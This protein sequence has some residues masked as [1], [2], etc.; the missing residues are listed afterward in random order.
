MKFFVLGAH[1]ELSRTEIETVTGAKLVSLAHPEIMLLDGITTP[2]TELQ[3]RLAGVI[4][5]GTIVGSL[6]GFDKQKTADLI[7][8]Y[9][10][11]YDGK[12][13]FG[14]STYDKRIAK[15][16]QPLGLEVKKRLKA[17]GVSCRLVTSRETALSSVVVQ[18]NHLLEK[19]GEFIVIPNGHE[20]LIGKTET[21]QN[22]EAWSNRD[23]GR[24]ARNAKSGMLP[25]KLARIMLNLTG[26]EPTKSSVLDPFCGSGT[27]LME[28]QLLGFKKIYGSD[29]SKQAIQD[30]KKNLAWLARGNGVSLTELKHGDATT[31][32]LVQLV[33]AIVTE[34]YL[35]RPQKGGETAQ[36]LETIRYE[37]LELY[38]K[39]FSH[40]LTLLKPNG[41]LVVSFPVIGEI[42][43][44]PKIKK[45]RELNTPIFYKREGQ[46][47]GRQIVRWQKVKADT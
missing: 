34:P 26:L 43:V 14:I 46:R 18:K 25:P 47:I 10:V 19:G 36:Q 21:V 2:S 17:D 32:K 33:D 45:V 1:P 5:V 16:I 13:Q 9:I 24:P 15:Q 31:L 22:F 44:V 40:L 6:K 8:S 20:T 12:V 38:E 4:K 11:A 39:T 30:S 23:F 3:E 27:V 28:A 41:M 7:R 29:L 37:L 35:G 42:P